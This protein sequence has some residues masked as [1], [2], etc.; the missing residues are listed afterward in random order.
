MTFRDSQVPRRLQSL[1]WALQFSR[2]A[3]EPPSAQTV[4]NVRH[5]PKERPRLQ[6]L[7]AFIQR[8]IARALQQSRFCPSDGLQSCESRLSDQRLQFWAHTDREQQTA[9]QQ[10]ALQHQTKP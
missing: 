10:I 3:A 6:N 8:H 5:T 7:L 9:S 1:F 2:G 4:R